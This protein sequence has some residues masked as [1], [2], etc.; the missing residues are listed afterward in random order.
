M[1]VR[2]TINSL[3][4]AQKISGKPLSELIQAAR[5]GHRHLACKRVDDGRI[6]FVDNGI[7][8][9]SNTSVELPDLTL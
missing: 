4:T 8:V 3:Y 1:I 6:P 9:T 5:Q 7:P 2:N